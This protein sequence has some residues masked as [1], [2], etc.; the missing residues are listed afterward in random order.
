MI[1]ILKHCIASAP[2]TDCIET[3]RS[4]IRIS[5]CL[6]PKEIK[7]IEDGYFA[8]V[9]VVVGAGWAG[10]C[11]VS[12]HWGRF[13]TT[14][15]TSCVESVP[16]CILWTGDGPTCSLDH[17]I[18]RFFPSL[19]TNTLLANRALKII[20]K[21]ANNNSYAN[22]FTQNMTKSTHQCP[23]KTKSVGVWSVQSWVIHPHVCN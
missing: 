8:M 20:V 22:N 5:S 19:N 14:N 6:A 13:F 17:C 23:C 11:G 15:V 4:I 2:H 21:I 1:M 10:G 3:F 12:V 9:V 16:A 18:S 7:V